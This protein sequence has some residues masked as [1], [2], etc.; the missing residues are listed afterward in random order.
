MPKWAC[1]SHTQARESD[2]PTSI[3]HR[4]TGP[5]GS[6][7]HK[8]QRQELCGSGNSANDVS[9]NTHKDASNT[10]KGLNL[11]DSPG[12]SPSCNGRHLTGGSLEP[13]VLNVL[14][15]RNAF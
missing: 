14:F 7:R 10:S 12:W 11:P 1:D 6:R 2:V 8:I 9:K 3:G 5:L 13:S 4:M 15:S